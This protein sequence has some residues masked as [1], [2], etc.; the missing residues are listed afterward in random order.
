MRNQE[1]A[2]R[3]VRRYVG[4]ALGSPPWRVRMRMD[5]RFQR[6]T[7]LVQDTSPAGW[8]A[9]GVETVAGGMQLSIQLFPP[10]ASSG[11]ENQ[12][13]AQRAADQL[14]DAI[15]MGV[16]DAHDSSVRG[17][18][19]LIPLWSYTDE[20]G[21]PLP[22]GMRATKRTPKDFLRV[23]PGWSFQ[24]IPEAPDDQLFVAL[25]DLRVQWFRNAG[26]AEDGALLQSVP[27][28]V[29]STVG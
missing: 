24:A 6:P 9:G 8:T 10:I 20:D 17:Y 27:I 22:L 28:D 12:L 1:D 2:I 23:M 14:S 7:A 13:L 18:R 5:G 19:E 16:V 26:L 15:I 29:K 3:S 21:D 4:S 25:G 11:T